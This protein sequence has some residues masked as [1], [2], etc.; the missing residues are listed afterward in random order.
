[1][2]QKTTRD[3]IDAA[4]P[5][6]LPDDSQEPV[7]VRIQTALSDVLRSEPFRASKQSQ[8]LLRFIVDNTLSGNGELLKERLIGV[9]VFRRPADYDTS[10]DPIVRSRATEVRKRLAQ[11]YVGEGASASIRIQ[12][13]RG[14]YHATFS[15]PS[16]IE[17][18]GA[19]DSLELD[20]ALHAEGNLLSDNLAQPFIVPPGRVRIGW[21][22][23]RLLQILLV[24]TVLVSILAGGLYWSIKKSAAEEFWFPLFQ[25]SRPILICS[26]SFQTGTEQKASYMTSGNLFASVKVAALLSSKRQNFDMRSA[27]GITSDDMRAFPAVLIGFDNQW[28]MLLNDDLPFAFISGKEFMIVDNSSSGRRWAALH[29]ADG[30]RLTDYAIVT[31]VISSK[32]GQSTVILAGLTENG[33][34]AA[35]DFVTNP[36]ELGRAMATA[37]KGWQK[38]NIEFLLQINLVHG[39]SGSP[40]VIAARYW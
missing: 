23:F 9:E 26:G 10:A 27:T 4:T 1:M 11:Y 15:L 35:A 40:T 33:T 39:I 30:N 14:S 16:E 3:R 37:P 7:A 24:A 36:D 18:E 17:D 31:R 21:P 6:G 8:Q 29:S 22:Q 13:N 28:A 34:R 25:Q 12:I 19:D 2:P 5:D 38:K 20:D 32:T